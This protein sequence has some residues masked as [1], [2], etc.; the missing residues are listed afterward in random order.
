MADRVGS[1]VLQGTLLRTDLGI[2]QWSREFQ[3]V[4]RFSPS[5]CRKGICQASNGKGLVAL[6]TM[7]APM[8]VIDSRRTSCVYSKET[9]HYP[10][11]FAWRYRYPV[12][13]SLSLPCPSLGRRL[14][15]LGF[16]LIGCLCPG[17]APFRTLLR[18]RHAGRLSPSGDPTLRSR[19]PSPT[20]CFRSHSGI[21]P[22]SGEAA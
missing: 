6:Y 11:V 3:H 17:L 2:H 4:G 16:V 22:Y 15:R 5:L 19:T 21:V 14:G 1:H 7:R 20:C 18:A 9:R 10:S 8:R 12:V 13:D